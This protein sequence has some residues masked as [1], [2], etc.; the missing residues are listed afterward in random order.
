MRIR[1]VT[2]ACVLCAAALSAAPAVAATSRTH[3]TWL[4]AAPANGHVSLALPLKADLTGLKRLA[5][6]VSD[7]RSPQY[8]QYDSI[9]N[10]ARRFG[11]PAAALGDSTGRLA[12]LGG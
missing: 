12:S 5:A 10:L 3:W 1:V 11:A 9:A 7:P 6:A 8:G 4:G 2:A